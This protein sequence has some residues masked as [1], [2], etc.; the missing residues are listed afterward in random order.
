MQ[1]AMIMTTCK[2]SE[3][4]SLR[5]FGDINLDLFS[6][7]NRVKQCISYMTLFRIHYHSLSMILALVAKSMSAQYIC[8]ILTEIQ[9]V[10]V[11][12]S[13]ADPVVITPPPVGGLIGLSMIRAAGRESL[14]RSLL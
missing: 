1:L 11:V 2:A 7:E 5:N 3:P 14:L 6:Q 9:A 10:H 13:M 8:Y 4:V 12:T